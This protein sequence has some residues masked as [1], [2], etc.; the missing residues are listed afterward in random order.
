MAIADQHEHQQGR[1]RRPPQ[2][3]ALGWSVLIGAWLG[4]G[5][6][7]MM[8]VFGLA[9]STNAGAPALAMIWAGLV[10]CPAVGFVL[11]RMGRP[12]Y[13]PARFAA[14]AVPFV[15]AVMVVRQGVDPPK[16]V[17]PVDKDV[18][19]YPGLA[20]KLL[21]PR[22]RDPESARLTDLMAFKTGQQ[23]TLC[24]QIN[25]KNGFGGYGGPQPFILSDNGVF[26][27]EAEAT[28]ERVFA[29]CKGA[30]TTVV[31]DSMLD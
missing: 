20:M 17:Q 15:I 11:D 16:P 23:L 25:A 14:A 24:G 6:L 8:G 10:L 12:A 28:G 4:S 18:A 13:R 19:I 7:V 5:L 21:T 31:P 3:T 26:L 30:I 1:R 22:L 27:G 9:Q 2:R 29:E